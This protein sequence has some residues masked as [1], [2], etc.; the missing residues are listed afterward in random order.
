LSLLAFGGG[1][2]AAAGTAGIGTVVAAGGVSG[3]AGGLTGSLI[4]QAGLSAAHTGRVSVNPWQVGIDTVAGGLGG[5]VTAGLLHGSPITFST[6]IQAGVGGGFVAGGFGGGAGAWLRGEDIVRGAGLGSLQG[7]LL[8]GA[9]GALGYGCYRGAE[10]MGYLSATGESQSVADL[11]WR[12]R[13]VRGNR[14]NTARAGTYTYDEVYVDDP[15]GRGYNVVDSY[16][17]QAGEIVSRK[18]TQFS[19]VTETTGLAYVRE[20][21]RKYAPGLRI[22]DVP[23]NTD[24]GI[25]GQTLRGQMIL[26][27]P[28][29]ARP[30]PQAVLDAA[31]ARGILIRDVNG[32]VY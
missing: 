13:V 7:A 22:A 8:G 31:A 2:A 9:G 14:F 28:V 6:S 11:T 25:A 12:A 19:E 26:E 27:V 30:I 16:D 18:S 29:Q 21:A 23:T 3:M 4:Q 1:A 5:M 20:L 15:S 24:R 10:A 32:R 17:I